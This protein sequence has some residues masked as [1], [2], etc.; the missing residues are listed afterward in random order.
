MRI[1]HYKRTVNDHKHTHTRTFASKS[2]QQSDLIQLYLSEN[3]LENVYSLECVT[4]QES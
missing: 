1:P 3:E 4:Q 2:M